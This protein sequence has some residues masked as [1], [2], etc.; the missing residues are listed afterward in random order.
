MAQQPDLEHS[1]MKAALETSCTDD[2]MRDTVESLKES[3]RQGNR[4][5][6]GTIYYLSYTLILAASLYANQ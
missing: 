6:L 2:Y 1:P 4:P 3:S 5:I